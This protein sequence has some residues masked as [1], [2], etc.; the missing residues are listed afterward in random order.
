MP[1]TLSR[2]PPL[3]LALSILLSLALRPALSTA[4]VANVTV[5][6]S[7]E[8]ISYTPSSSWHASTDPC[9]T[10][11]RPSF[12]EAFGGTWHE[13]LHTSEQG[14]GGPVRTRLRHGD[15]KSHVFTNE[16]DH[17]DFN[18]TKGNGDYLKRVRD[19]LS[20]AQDPSSV[21]H[22]AHSLSTSILEND[23]AEPVGHVVSA[24]F[25]FTVPEGV[26]PVNSAPTSM[27]LTFLLDSYIVGDLTFG[28]H[29]LTIQIGSN[30]V[31]LLDYIVYAEEDISGGG[32]K[33]NEP[34]TS[35]SATPGARESGS[36]TEST[37]PSGGPGTANLCV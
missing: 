23:D 1:S 10:C 14:H 26:A 31:L 12:D 30:S 16:E 34:N 4:G 36:G 32:D 3:L 20:T 35:A 22:G 24:Q 2:L 21:P 28:P 29:S 11:L 19:V 33:P 18:L 13:G 5:D 6:D 17:H 9:P 15:N 8:L 7:S 37:A 25:S 27:N